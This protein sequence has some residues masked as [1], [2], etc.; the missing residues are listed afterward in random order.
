MW[1]TWDVS[2]SIEIS[3]NTLKVD[4]YYEEKGAGDG[5]LLQHPGDL[6]ETGSGCFMVG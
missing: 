4:R 6:Y 3:S 1:I 2:Q 5:A